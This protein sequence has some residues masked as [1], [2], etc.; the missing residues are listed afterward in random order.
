MIGQKQRY[1]PYASSRPTAHRSS[2][3]R[4]AVRFEAAPEQRPQARERR[5]HRR[6]RADSPAPA[7][8]IAACLTSRRRTLSRLVEE[9]ESSVDQ[10]E[11]ADKPS[12]VPRATDQGGSGVNTEEEAMVARIGA[13]V[14]VPEQ[15]VLSAPRRMRRSVKV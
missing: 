14:L 15:K 3:P 8:L 5:D 4:Q 13:L 6:R 10:A 7:E 1:S 11:V 9:D 12:D 2:R